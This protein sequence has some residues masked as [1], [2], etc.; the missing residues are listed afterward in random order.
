MNYVWIIGS[1]NFITVSCGSGRCCQTV[2]LSPDESY[3][4]RYWY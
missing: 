1:S 4:I 2:E 3:G